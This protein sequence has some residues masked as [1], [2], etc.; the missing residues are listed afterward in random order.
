M[1]RRLVIALLACAAAL[2]ARPAPAGAVLSG[3]NGRIVYISG[4]PFG[5]TKLS[6]RTV[7]S[8]TGGGSVSGPLDTGLTDQHRHPTWS[9]DRTKIAFAEGPGGATGYDIY[10]LDLT[11][12]GATPQ[13]IT[14]SSGVTDDRPAWSP[15]GTRI[16][17][18]SGNDIIVHP[19]NGGSD[20]N[21]T[22]TLTPKAWKAAWSPDSQTLYYS[23]G[24][25]TQNPN[26]NNNDIRLYQ[27]P[28]D[29]SAVG[30]ELVHISGAHAFQPSI[31]PD[32]TKLCY[33]VSTAAG[34][35][36]SASVVA[37]PLSSPTSLTVIA[38]SGKGDYNC[39]WSPDG[40][41]IAYTED[42]GGNGEIFMRNSNATGI[43][44]NLTNNTGVYDGNPDWA[45]DG[46]P[47]CPDRTAWVFKNTPTTITMRCKDTGPAYER[48]TVRESVANNGSPTHGTLSNLMIDSPSTVLYT[49]NQDF[50]GTDSM[51]IIGFDD[52]GFGNQRGTITIKVFSNHFKIGKPKLNKRRGTAILP[53][54]IPGPGKL[55]LFG[56]G[57]KRK[58]KHA[59]QAGKVRLKVKPKGKAKRKLREHHSAKVK[60]KVTYAP[61]GGKL[62]T[63]EKT[64]RL[65]RK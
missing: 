60:A 20:L 51:Q 28:A 53:V 37:A 12:P 65:V 5:A 27:Q 55:V 33:T 64:V 63:K 14:N 13:D 36:T 45:P 32:G 29:N 24:D 56:K 3:R 43:P 59:A 42:F 11:T 31:S 58:A 46:P 52:F 48:T 18:E 23:V 49:P 25:I 50:L 40:T 8:S 41:K 39:T 4:P 26:G 35:S 44:I 61:T 62:R 7:T 9:P 15:D 17:Y 38:D 57:V 54:R 6:L 21:L 1:A 34:N 10:I 2:S 47:T 22:S 19:L 30:T 16:A